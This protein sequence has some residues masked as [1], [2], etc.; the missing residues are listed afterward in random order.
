MQ[1]PPQT[2]C[3][4]E[5]LSKTHVCL[6]TSKPARQGS[7]LQKYQVEPAVP[8]PIVAR[9]GLPFPP[10]RIEKQHNAY[11]GGHNGSNNGAAE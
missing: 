5:V 9:L 3:P 7:L 11:N 10:L 1:P 6:N 4:E 2:E 8:T